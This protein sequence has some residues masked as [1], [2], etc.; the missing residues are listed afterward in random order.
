MS[1]VDCL[2]LNLRVL[3]F[4]TVRD[5]DPPHRRAFLMF[6]WVVIDKPRGVDPQAF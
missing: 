5:G 4:S 6:G 1:H 2:C 3:V